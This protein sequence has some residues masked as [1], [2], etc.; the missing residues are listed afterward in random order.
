MLIHNHKIPSVRL[1]RT[2]KI[3]PSDLEHYLEE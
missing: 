3:R 2:I 1:G